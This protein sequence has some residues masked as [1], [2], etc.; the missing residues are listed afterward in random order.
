MKPTQPAS[1]RAWQRM[2]S[3]RRLNL[4]DPS[5]LDIEIEDIAVGLARVARW[6]GQT[7]GDWALS[8]A[9]HSL[10]V[11]EL[12]GR[13]R[14]DVPAAWRLLALLHDA[15]EYVIGDLITPFKTTLGRDYAAIEQRLMAAVRVRFGLAKLPKTADNLIKRADRA[16]AFI[17]ATKVAGF[18]QD[19]A[20]RL[21]DPKGSLKTLGLDGMIL[22]PY[23]PTEVEADFLE[24]FYQIMH[25]VNET[26]APP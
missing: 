4:L 9:Q 13:F 2:L 16:A 6:N 10:L 1:G 17:E 23:P 11:E 3:G 22:T 12:L 7:S 5:P 25:D 18:P 8:V 15:P 26:A 19:E 20:R 14:E 24:R 21:F